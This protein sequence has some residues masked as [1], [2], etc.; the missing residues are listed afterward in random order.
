MVS[1]MP[2]TPIL[3]AQTVDEQWLEIVDSLTRRGFIW[4]G[5]GAAALAVLAACGSDGASTA[6][7]NPGTGAAA[8]SVPTTP[9]RI[10]SIDYFTAIFLV[11]LGVTPAGAIDFSWVDDS[12]MYPPYVPVLK[13]IPSIGEI[14]A[15][16]LE[17]VVQ[18]TPDLVIG[19]TPGSRYDNSPGALD[20]LHAR[21][22]TV[23][24]DFG[25]S[26]DWRP[27]FA[28][29]ADAV[30]RRAQLDELI[31][32]YQASLASVKAAHADTLAATTWALLSYAEDGSVSIDMPDSTA[33]VVLT[34]LGVR[35]TSAVAGKT[36]GYQDLSLEQIDQLAD[37]DA[38]L[39]RADGTGAPLNGLADVFAYA[40]WNNLPAAKAGRVLPIT[41]SDLCTYRWAQLA[42]DDLDQKM[43]ALS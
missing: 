17:S 13:T 12:S 11:E 22:P 29:T 35:W 21:F 19:P 31:A 25:T 43:S 7:S 36:G 37:A 23:S 26:G 3:E 15:T 8:S 33:G 32:G 18:L 9:Q 5:A 2:T 42:L 38:I 41:W 40:G 16:N 14:T 24:V 27:P 39:F 4:S 20:A 10:V 34:D 6:S 1:L 28:A 30:G